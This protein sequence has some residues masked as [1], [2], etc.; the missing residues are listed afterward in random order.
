MGS[1]DFNLCW[2][3]SKSELSINRGVVRIL[4]CVDTDYNFDL[5]PLNFKLGWHK[6]KSKLWRGSKDFN[7]CWHKYQWRGG[8]EFN[9]CWQRQRI[10]SLCYKITKG[11][12]DFPHLTSP[13]LILTLGFRFVSTQIK[14]FTS[15]LL[16]LILS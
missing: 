7:W 11:G 15:P 4:I 12:G 1:K 9:L 13:S 10:R 16:I 8:K 6:S 2:H 5:L 14:M 3:R